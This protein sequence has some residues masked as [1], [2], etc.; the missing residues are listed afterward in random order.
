L[1]AK[2][3]KKELTTT[4]ITKATVSYHRQGGASVEENLAVHMAFDKSTAD[5]FYDLEQGR[6]RVVRQ[7][8]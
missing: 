2:E 1:Y 3:I 6:T 4:V 8:W 5:G 7:L